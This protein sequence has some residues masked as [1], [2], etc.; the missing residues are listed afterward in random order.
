MQ[1]QISQAMSGVLGQV[2][3]VTIKDGRRFIGRLVGVDSKRTL[4]LDDVLEE[5]PAGQVSPVSEKLATLENF[6]SKMSELTPSF[7]NTSGV[8]AE[9][10][11]KAQFM[12]NKIRH[13]AVVIPGDSVLRVLKQVPQPAGPEPAKPA[14][15]PG[16]PAS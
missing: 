8:S 2:V 6:V 4:M 1:I 3:I 11:F 16:Q 9:G 15:A 14:G 5:L 10:A 7:I 13:L 12:S